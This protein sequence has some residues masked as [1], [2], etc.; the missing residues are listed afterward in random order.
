[1]SKGYVYQNEN[2]EATLPGSGRT[3]RGSLIMSSYYNL[4]LTAATAYDLFTVPASKKFIITGIYL[5]ATNV[6]GYVSDATAS[7]G[8]NATNY[9]DY[10]GSLTAQIPAT[11][12][13]NNATMNASQ[14]FKTYSAGDVIKFN[15][16]A[17]AVATNYKITVDLMGYLI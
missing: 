16:T 6:S 5:V 7:V 15:V 3:L 13:V 10:I 1:M 4:D 12:S 8:A 17:A 11:D 9:D 2:D 14:L